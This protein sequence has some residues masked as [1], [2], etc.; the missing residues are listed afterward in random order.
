MDKRWIVTC[1]MLAA[2]LT[3][4][5]CDSSTPTEEPAAPQ[6]SA[7][8]ESERDQITQAKGM[9][10]FGGWG[11]P[12]PAEAELP[13]KYLGD[14][15]HATLKAPTRIA[16]GPDG[17]ILVSDPLAGAWHAF[18]IAGYHKHTVDGLQK[19]LAIGADEFDSIYVGDNGRGAVYIYRYPDRQ[20]GQ[21]YRHQY[22]AYF[23]RP[24]PGDLARLGCAGYDAATWGH[25]C[26]AAG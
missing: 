3:I 26:T 15:D 11:D 18:T 7:P 4:A 13:L 19:P 2:V 20:I 17:D 6:P 8:A 9:G 21:C 24:N 5:G 14:V 22:P 10:G 16:A 25:S 1:L 12:P 23:R